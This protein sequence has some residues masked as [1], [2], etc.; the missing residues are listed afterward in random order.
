MRDD[1]PRP[2][3]HFHLVTAKFAQVAIESEERRGRRVVRVRAVNIL[4]IAFNR[5]S[6]QCKRLRTPLWSSGAA[7]ASPVKA[8]PHRAWPRTLQRAKSFFDGDSTHGRHI[9]LREDDPLEG[10][11]VREHDPRRR[12]KRLPKVIGQPLKRLELANVLD[13]LL[14]KA[15]GLEIEAFRRMN[16]A[17]RPSCFNEKA[18]RL[19][20]KDCAHPLA[21]ES[22]GCA[23]TR[24]QRRQRERRRRPGGQP[25]AM[26]SVGENSEL[27]VFAPT[28]RHF[29]SAPR[30]RDGCDSTERS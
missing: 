27:D 20:E 1:Q 21:V 2:R 14:R 4:D 16:S 15:H 13:E 12:Q 25:G 7:S 26:P 30:A 29:Y 5:L 9:V 10:R 8:D 17:L 6:R 28:S 3:A 19:R 24:S 23:T 11:I 18:S 22:R